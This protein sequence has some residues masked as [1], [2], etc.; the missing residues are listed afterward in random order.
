MNAP[1]EKKDRRIQRT[2]EALT[3]AMIALALEKGYADITIRDLTERA[4]IGY[5]TFFRHFPDKEALLLN[6]LQVFVAELM[7]LFQ[8]RAATGPGSGAVVF[9]YIQANHELC[10]V[11]LSSPGSASLVRHIQET[12]VAY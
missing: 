3:R 11:L 2:E 4:G 7:A 9:R 12:V 10:R 5:A 6:V 8:D 1:T